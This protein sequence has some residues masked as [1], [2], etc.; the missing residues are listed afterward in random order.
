MKKNKNTK[1]KNQFFHLDV[2][3]MNQWIVLITITLLVLLGMYLMDSEKSTS[4]QVMDMDQVR[5]AMINEQIRNRIAAA[6]NTPELYQPN[7]PN[8]NKEE[9]GACLPSQ[10]DPNIWTRKC[11][12]KNSEGYPLGMYTT[13]RTCVVCK[14]LGN[15]I[16]QCETYDEQGQYVGQTQTKIG[17]GFCS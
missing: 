8:V 11:V 5:I 7:V 6:R 17:M 10:A 15:R 9:C 13:E 3:Q 14:D 16:K 12:I 4:Q 2:Y 1:H